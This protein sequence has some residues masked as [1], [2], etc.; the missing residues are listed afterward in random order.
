MSAIYSKTERLSESAL[1][2]RLH[3]AEDDGIWNPQVTP[4]ARAH[5]SNIS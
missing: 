5:L 2:S 3:Y 4:R 1:S